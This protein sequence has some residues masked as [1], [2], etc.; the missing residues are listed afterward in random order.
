MA[1]G[2]T[3]EHTTLVRAANASRDATSW[4]SPV[5]IGMSAAAGPSLDRTDSSFAWLRPPIAQRRS[6]RSP[7]RAA[8]FSAASLPVKPVAPHSTMSNS[9]SCSMAVLSSHRH[10]LPGSRSFDHLAAGG[11]AAS[12]PGGSARGALK[13]QAWRAT[14]LGR[15][16]ELP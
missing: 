3:V 8:N 14:G 7:M 13:Q 4:L 11:E 16:A 12:P 5:T 15:P 9:E 10:A 2:P 6:P 1:Y